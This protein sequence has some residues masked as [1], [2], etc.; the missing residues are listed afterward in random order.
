MKYKKFLY[1]LLSLIYMDFIYNI[2]A[3]DNYL[4]TSIINMILFALIG[5]AF[6]TIITSLFKEKVNKIIT[7]VIYIFLWFWYNLHYIFYKV[8]VSPF[9]MTLLKQSD[10]TLKFPKNIVISILQNFHMLV[11][12]FLPIV[13]LI[14]FKKK[15]KY[16][17]YNYKEIIKYC[18]VFV[19]AISIYVGNIFVQPREIGGIYNLYYETNNVSLNIENLGVMG[20]TYLDVKR[21]IFGFNEKIMNVDVLEEEPKVSNEPKI[22]EYE[23]NYSDLDFSKGNNEIINNYIKNEVGTK[24]NE[25]TGMFKNKNLVFIV[26]ESFS[27]IAVSEKYTPTLYKLVHE[28]FYFK[29]FYTSNNLSTIGGEFQALTGLYADNTILS[30]W[31]GGWAFYPYGLGN[32][33]KKLGYNTFAYHDNSAYYQDRNVY[34]KTQGFDNFKGCYNGLEQLINCEQWPQSDIEM[35]NA[36]V[37]DY[38]NSDKPFM[39]YYMTVSGHFYYTFNDNS[40]SNKNKDLVSDLNYPEDIKGYIATQIELDRAIESLMNKLKEAN[41]LDDTVF[42]LLGDHYPYNLP[43]DH[44]NLLSDY[45]RDGLIEANSNALILYNSKMEPIEV[46]KVGMSI[47]VLPTVLNLFGVDYDSRII[48]G[49]DILST[50]EGIAIF[51][52]KSWV[53]NKG[54]YYASSG[55]FVSNDEEVSTDYINNINNIVNNRV[56]ISRMIVDSN[57]YK[58]IF[59]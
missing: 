36:T 20:A 13:L 39:T 1:I 25:Y 55:R 3:Y 12:F 8:F 49:K 16:E 30:S 9:S 58:S 24:Q 38:I 56:A 51:K 15:I 41:K 50:T 5:A 35:M 54:T 40:I 31:R 17:K 21:L 44:I 29:N 37:N 34:L 28:G 7:Y 59:D 53:T 45:E 47:D 14:I 23:Y 19:L 42:V 11:L 43:I 6:I 32:T 4:I 18:C 57:Y 2:F 52:D 48:M 33:F 10:Q 22:I 46:D 27:E 26:A